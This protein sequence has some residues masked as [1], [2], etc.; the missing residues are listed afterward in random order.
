MNIA[1]LWVVALWMARIQQKLIV[2]F[3]AL[4]VFIHLKQKINLNRMKLFVKNIIVIQK[5]A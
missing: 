5:N 2:I 1:A 3:V 4:T